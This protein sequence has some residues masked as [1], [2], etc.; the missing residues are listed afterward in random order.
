MGTGL[1]VGILSRLLERSPAP[2][3]SATEHLRIGAKKGTDAGAAALAA[4]GP[5]I[6]QQMNSKELKRT[7][8]E[9]RKQ[10]VSARDDLPKQVRGFFR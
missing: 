8:K 9:V 5:K 4:W 7:A 1:V 2:D 10:V 6:A 3:L